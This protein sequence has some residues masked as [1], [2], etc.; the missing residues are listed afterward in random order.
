MYSQIKSLAKDFYGYLYYLYTSI[1]SLIGLGLK[2]MFRNKASDTMKHYTHCLS[3][4][5]CPF[6]HFFLACFLVL[7]GGFKSRIY[8][9]TN[10]SEESGVNVVMA[11]TGGPSEVVVPL[12][13]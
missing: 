7:V 12:Y 8:L 9:P 6:L 4:L 11:L 3:I 5:S 13:F 2:D 1:C 10:L